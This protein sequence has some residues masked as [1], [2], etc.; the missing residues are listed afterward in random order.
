MYQ[1]KISGIFTHR[2]AALRV[3]LSS[4]LLFAASASWAGFITNNEAG[5]DAIF[6][7]SGFGA[8]T[9]DTRFN[10]S[11]SVANSSLLSIDSDAE[12]DSLSSLSVF[13]PPN[14][15]NIF[16]VD[17]ITF[18]GGSGNFVGCASTPGNL[19]ALQSS[20]ASQAR[21]AIG[22]AHEIGHNLGLDHVGSSGTN[23]M[24]PLISNNSSLDAAQISTILGS[25][26]IQGAPGQRFLSITEIAIVAS[27]PEPQTWMMFGLGLL[28]IVGWARS[29]T[30]GAI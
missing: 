7:Q 11:R 27:V 17:A 3:V 15:I 26:L 20:F 18:C 23:L 14:T 6:S 16:F 13:S 8:S 5:L 25:S 2:F 1:S 12:F 30:A 24:N 21:G 4:L 28:G 22:E 9:I 10:A 29:R 19:I